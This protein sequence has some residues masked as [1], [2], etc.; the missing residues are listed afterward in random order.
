[1]KTLI[2]SIVALTFSASAVA[3]SW[4]SW[5]DPTKPFDATQPRVFNGSIN[6]EWRLADNVNEACEKASKSF[7]NNGFAGQKMQGCA[8][9][10]GEK[11]VIITKKKPT[12]HTVGHEMRHC[13]YG[14]WH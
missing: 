6:I 4:E 9:W 8:F 11:C 1:M 13:F 12:M 3:Q 2:A 14:A 7:G 10:W 5:D